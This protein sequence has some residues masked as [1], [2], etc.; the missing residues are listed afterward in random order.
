MSQPVR[1]LGNCVAAA[2]LAIALVACSANTAASPAAPSGST[3][4]STAPPIQV[5][6]EAPLSGD[7]ASNG[8]DMFEGA[9]L[10][11]DELN[12][13]GGVL[14]RRIQLVP[15][16]DQGDPATGMEV[17]SRMVNRGV[18]AV[19]GPYNSSVGIQNLKTYLDAGTV[20]IHLTS[21]K[22]T[23]GMGVT[24]QPKDYQIAPVEA[25][26]I[27]GYFHAKTVAIVYDP[28]TYTGGIAADVK[29]ALEQAG[30]RVLAYEKVDPGKSDYL[31]LI[32]QVERLKPDLLYVSTY[33][34]Q[35][36]IIAK[37]LA[38]M[39]TNMPSSAMLCLMGLANQDPAFADAAGVSAARLC[40]FSGVPAPENFPGAAQYVKD[41][42]AKVGSEPGTWGTFTYDSVKLL[43]DAVT[44]AG[45]WDKDKVRDALSNTKGYQGITGVITID[46]ATGNRVDVPV[47]ILSLGTDGKYSVDP[48]WA[49]FAGFGR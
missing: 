15:A 49:E 1:T 23:N 34:P 12:A 16:D 37:D 44:R 36:A 13:H 28:Q 21:N 4:A 24:V 30:L 32:A 29:K 48:K 45:A 22:A 19:V 9:R 33:Y 35:G 5:A 38:K 42:E 26:A 11:V 40:R 3:T 17:A 2:G 18:F 41:Y 6:L 25:K 14:G 20:V 8:T 27:D 46:K 7:Q 31:P 47:V 39:G 10:A 43:A